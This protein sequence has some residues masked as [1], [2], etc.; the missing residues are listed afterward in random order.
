MSHICTLHGMTDG[1]P[2]HDHRQVGCQAQR[3]ELSFALAGLWFDHQMSFW[4]QVHLGT[5]SALRKSHYHE[6][7]RLYP[8]CRTRDGT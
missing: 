8:L 2:G 1:K 7:M 4:I 3:Q 6:H 5:Q